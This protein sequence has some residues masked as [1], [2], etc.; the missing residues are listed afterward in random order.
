MPR[1]NAEA[2]LQREW[3]SLLVSLPPQRVNSPRWFLMP[4]P[5]RPLSPAMLFAEL[6]DVRRL[7]SELRAYPLERFADRYINSAWTLRQLLAHLASWA[8]EF[9]FEVETASRGEPFDYSIPFA[10]SVIGP[11]QWNQVEVEKRAASSLEEILGEF[12]SETARLQDLV[13]A[14]P[15]ESLFA[16]SAFPAAPTGDPAARWRGNSAQIALMKC[17]HDRYH[18]GRIQQWLEG[19]AREAESGENR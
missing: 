15:P 16:E 1:R 3:Q 2:E 18:L 11:N 7:W 10:L 19:V 14:L 6:E 4:H 5:M 9:R 13:L 12:D 8:R 17:M